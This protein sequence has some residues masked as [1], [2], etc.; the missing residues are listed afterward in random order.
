IIIETKKELID[1]VKSKNLIDI[2]TPS[3]INVKLDINKK[4]NIV[5]LNTRIKK[6]DLIENV[7][8]QQFNKDYMDLRIKYLGKLEKVINQLKKEN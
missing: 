8:V 1:L 2:R 7:F 3:F 6:I 4:S 5:E